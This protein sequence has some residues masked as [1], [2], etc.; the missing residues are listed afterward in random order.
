MEDSQEEESKD[1][2]GDVR[3]FFLGKQLKDH[4]SR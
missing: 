1:K 4:V 2:D 3:D